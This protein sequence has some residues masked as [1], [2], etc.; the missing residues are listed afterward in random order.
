MRS[1]GSPGWSGSSG[2]PSPRAG[3]T[4]KPTRAALLGFVLAPQ[5]A[6]PAPPDDGTVGF[7]RA[8]GEA[9]EVREVFRRCADRRLA[10]DDVEI[11]SADAGTYG[12]LIYE[13]ALRLSGENAKAEGL[14]VTFADGLSARYFRPGRALAAW[15]EWVRG[16]FAP[17]PL[18]RMIQ[19]GLLALPA[20][21]PGRAGR[22]RMA[23]V[24]RSLPIGAERGRYLP[25]I[26]A[27]IR[28]AETRLRRPGGG[29][30]DGDGAGQSGKLRLETLRGLRRVVGDL[31][32]LAPDGAGGPV[33]ALETALKL[34]ERS[35]RVAGEMDGYARQKLGQE[36]SALRDCL[37]DGRAVPGFEAWDW[38]ADLPASIR[39]GGQGPRPGCVHV[40]GI[41][42]GGHSG[43]AHVFVVGLDDARF[44]GGSRQDPLLLDDERRQLP[45][46]LP[47]ATARL[48]A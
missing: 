40:S 19:E 33:A 28:A 16:G 24:L 32:D 27:H 44:P 20:A 29:E 48:A 5:E 41:E 47:T 43:R 42:G 35:A 38:L 3:G 2:R 37:A 21:E 23:A 10:F 26:D 6:P 1:R 13:T 31:L 34:L 8:V 4:E 11:V 9:N 15:V 22:A 46:S 17:E 14:P 39:L 12:P 36:I 7:F 18:A 30:D 45:G 25:A